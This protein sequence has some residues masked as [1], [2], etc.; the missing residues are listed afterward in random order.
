MYTCITV[1]TD[2]NDNKLSL[3]PT[4]GSAKSPDLAIV[5]CGETY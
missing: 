3:N 4:I 2:D 1:D 5:L